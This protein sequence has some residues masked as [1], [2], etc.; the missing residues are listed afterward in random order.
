MGLPENIVPIDLSAELTSENM[1]VSNGKAVITGK[2]DISCIYSSEN[3]GYSNM[4]ATVPVKFEISAGETEIPYSYSADMK[5]SDMRMRLDNDKIY[6]DF[7]VSTCLDIAEKRI[8]PTVRAVKVLGESTKREDNGILT[9]CYPGENETLW[10]I[11][12]RYG[13]SRAELEAINQPGSRV[14]M[15]PSPKIRSFVV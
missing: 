8:Y 13:I 12:K 1:T 15:I 9:V 6:F 4:Q 11:S 10:D 14:L 5:A 2:A 3:N 7:E